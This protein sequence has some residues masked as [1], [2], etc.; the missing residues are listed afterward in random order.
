MKTL[1]LNAIIGWLIALISSLTLWSFEFAG[2]TFNVID[3]GLK[4]GI[5]VTNLWRD[6]E[7]LYTL[8]RNAES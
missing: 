5:T 3:Y 4:K 6:W 1:C 8:K 7:A 2:E